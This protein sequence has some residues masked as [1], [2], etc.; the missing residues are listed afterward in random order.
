MKKVHALR[1]GTAVLMLALLALETGVIHAQSLDTSQTGWETETS[2]SLTFS[3]VFGSLWTSIT[4]WLVND[5][6]TIDPGDSAGRG[7][8]T[9]SVP[10][11]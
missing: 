1:F 11:Q 8:G 10:W 5:S 7:H 2:Q 4:E 6:P 3:N 9:M